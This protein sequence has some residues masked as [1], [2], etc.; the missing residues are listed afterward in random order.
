MFITDIKKG[1]YNWKEGSFH[2]K[3]IFST[4]SVKSTKKKIIHGNFFLYLII[5]DHDGQ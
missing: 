5:D 2:R 3:K 1:P 4:R